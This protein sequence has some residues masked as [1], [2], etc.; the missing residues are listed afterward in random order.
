MNY[1]SFFL[2]IFALSFVIPKK[3]TIF[4]RFLHKMNNIKFYN[5]KQIQ[6]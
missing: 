6:F 1:F 2:L 3:R 5:K 4:A